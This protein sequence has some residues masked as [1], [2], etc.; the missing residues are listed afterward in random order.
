M[1]SSS[2]IPGP[3]ILSVLLL[4]GIAVCPSSN[5]G[6][7]E[8]APFQLALQVVY[9]DDSLGSESLRED[10]ERWIFR[11][12]A[13]HGCYASME[14]YGV[15]A[16]AGGEAAGSSN[17]DLLLRITL[18]NLEVHESW[19]VTLAERTAPDRAG[20]DMS[21]RITATVAFD[22]DMDFKLLPEDTTLR[23]REFAFH[24]TY[25]PSMGEDPREAVRMLVLEDL[26]RSARGF[27]CKGTKKLPR[28]IER[29]RSR[30]AD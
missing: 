25:R 1:R 26:A 6:S 17:P 2:Q 16:D 9:G 15:V 27:A 12:V 24:Q 19:D 23:K 3:G 22:V 13:S 10:V 5:A 8:A 7:T 30:P 14:R 4:L 20:E 21:D 29:T 28:E 18:T 11:E